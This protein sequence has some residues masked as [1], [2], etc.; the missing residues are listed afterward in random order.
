MAVFWVVT[1]CSLVEVY[2]SSGDHGNYYMRFFVI[3][4]KTD[5]RIFIACVVG[6]TTCAQKRDIHFQVIA[7]KF[8]VFVL[9]FQSRY[10]EFVF[11][12]QQRMG[13]RKQVLCVWWITALLHSYMT[14]VSS[15]LAHGAPSTLVR[16]PLSTILA[17]GRMGLQ[18]VFTYH[19]CFPPNPV[20][21]CWYHPCFKPYSLV[22]MEYLSVF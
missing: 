12:G 10:Q 13:R 14:F 4:L 3:R 6:K 11:A 22:T 19:V 8:V 7:R 9:E 5:I 2:L 1:P 20:I 15:E 18:F 17:F 21:A 16:I